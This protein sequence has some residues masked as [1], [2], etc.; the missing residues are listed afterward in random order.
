[1]RFNSDKLGFI[2]FATRVFSLLFCFDELFLQTFILCAQ[3]LY[4]S[5]ELGLF[6]RMLR[7]QLVN[8]CRSLGLNRFNDFVDLGLRKL[9]VGLASQ[10]LP[11]C[12][13]IR[14]KLCVLVRMS[15]KILLK[16]IN[17]LVCFLERCGLLSNS[18]VALLNLL[19]FRCKIFDVLLNLNF[20]LVYPFFQNEVIFL[21]LVQL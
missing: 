2:H 12:I 7:L 16:I 5:L 14:P 1:M 3:L 9:A 13:V 11:Q 18:I 21:L 17:F 8:R 20:K 19:L 15:V 6:L 4:R 10:L